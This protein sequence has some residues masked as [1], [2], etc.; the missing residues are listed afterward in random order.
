MTVGA[1]TTRR[2]MT[3]LRAGVGVGLASA[4]VVVAAGIG[5][6]RATAASTPGAE[7]EISGAP[8]ML[9]SSPFRDA[10]LYVD[11]ASN[12]RRAAAALRATDPQRAEILDRIGDHAQ[13][14]WFGDWNPASSVRGD[15]ADRIATIRRAGALPVL[16]AYAIPARDCGGYSTGGIGTPDGYRAWIEAFAAG[17]D[18]GPVAVILEPDA[19]AQM[20]TA[21]LGTREKVDERAALLRGAVETLTSRGAAVYLD[22]GNSGWLGAA[23]AAARLRQ[24]GVTAARGFAL[25]VSNYRTTSESVTYGRAVGSALGGKPFVVDTSRNG[26]GPT[27]DAEWCNPA[28]RAL[29]ARPTGHPVSGVDAYL[30]IK[31]PGESDGE[32]NGGPRAGEWWPE[33]AEGLAS[34]ASW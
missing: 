7:L 15:V 4:A 23:E 18:G 1:R 34:R 2:G 19:L 31:R 5:P 24:A 9:T 30:W 11:P 26:R 33:H 32:C 3:V 21:C 25:N 17:L 16:V 10:T 29:G 8:T 22:A 28:G 12:A 20:T 27:A 6:S 13:A 14:D